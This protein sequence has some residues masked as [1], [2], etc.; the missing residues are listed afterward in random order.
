MLSCASCLQPAAAP[1]AAPTCAPWNHHP[2]C[3]PNL[4]GRTALAIAA[5][6]L[7]CRPKRSLAIIE[8]LLAAGADP[9]CPDFHGIGSLVLRWG[10]G[11]GC[12]PLLLAAG[13]ASWERRT[14]R[15]AAICQLSPTPLHACPLAARTARRPFSSFFWIGCCSATSATARRRMRP[16]PQPPSPPLPAPLPAPPQRPPWLQARAAR[17]R[18]A[19]PQSSLQGWC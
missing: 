10:L 8:A 9:L 18:P 15:C 4:Q 7:D 12:R 19:P 14:L 5:Y 17:V 13:C 1:P 6:F 2:P 3:T 11:L 16:P